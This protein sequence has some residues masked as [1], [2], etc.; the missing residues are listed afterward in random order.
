LRADA[1]EVEHAKKPV[2]LKKPSMS[3]Q[4]TIL[5][6]GVPRSGTTLACHLLNKAPDTVALHEPMDVFT[7][8]ALRRRGGDAAVLDAISAFAAAQRAS[9]LEH[10]TAR[11]KAVDGKVPDN[12]ISRVASADG[13]RRSMAGLVQVSFG[14]PRASGFTLVMKHPSAFSALLPALVSRFQVA[15]V[16]R[17]PL[18]ILG[19]WASVRLAVHDG[20]APAAENLDPALHEALTARGERLERQIHLVGWFFE[21]FARWLPR[22]R[23]VRYEDMIA[24]GGAALGAITPAAASLAEPLRSNNASELYERAALRVAGARLLD[25]DG[26][27][28]QFYGREEVAAL[29]A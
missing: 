3:D 8:A 19:S 1:E 16:V 20:H 26:A 28:W 13:L 4:H 17:N 24:T 5:L 7:F 25:S 23:V 12:P 14:K 10:G 21:R 6:T 18:A 22:A 27:Y 2:I 15:A 29:L 9:L 11:S